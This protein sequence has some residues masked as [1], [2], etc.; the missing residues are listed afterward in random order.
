MIPGSGRSTGEGIA[1]LLQCSWAFL[2]AQVVK[3]PLPC[4]R[5]G[6]DP[7]VGKMPWRRER[8]PTQGLE[9]FK[10]CIVHGVAKSQTRPSDFHFDFHTWLG[11]FWAFYSV[12][13]IHVS[14][15]VPGLYCLD[16][17]CFVIEFEIRKCNAFNCVFFIKSELASWGLLWFHTNVGIV[18]LFL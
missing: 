3:N 17:Y 5:P 7:W 11:L 18:F 10:D 6:F 13:L 4:G 15:F 9:N 16:Y 14:V 2:V 1:Y 12:P 8:L